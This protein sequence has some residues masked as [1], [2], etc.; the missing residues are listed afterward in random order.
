MSLVGITP[1]NIENKGGS[2]PHG[3]ASGDIYEK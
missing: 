2:N 3:G 1:E